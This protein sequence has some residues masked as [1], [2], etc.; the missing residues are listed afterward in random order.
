MWHDPTMVPD[1]DP[2]AW[3]MLAGVLVAATGCG[4]R[5]IAQD[6]GA[7]E[8]A[9]ESG[10]TNSTTQ[11]EEDSPEC[12]YD[13]DCPPYST[14]TPEGYCHYNGYESSGED[15]SLDCNFTN[16]CAPF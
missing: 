1:F 5:T 3:N 16:E 11:S 10:T 13:S 8:G 6:S 9:D 4:G 12:I 7:T 14:C 15:V 2:R